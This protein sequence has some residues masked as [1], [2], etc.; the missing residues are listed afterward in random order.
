[1]LI[2][3]SS[4]PRSDSVLQAFKE[5]KQKC[6]L[7]QGAPYRRKKSNSNGETPSGPAPTGRSSI[8]QGGSPGSC[9]TT[10]NKRRRNRRY[11]QVRNLRRNL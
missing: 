9:A 11:C 8:A 2:S 3:T 1:V 4:Q 10:D 6:H 7:I 5:R